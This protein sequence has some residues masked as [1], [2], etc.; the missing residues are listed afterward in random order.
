MLQL[1]RAGAPSKDEYVPTG[2]SR[3]DMVLLLSNV[4]DNILPNTGP[5]AYVPAG[6]GIG[7]VRFKD[8]Q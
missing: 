6:H 7:A 5:G 4:E 1:L 3:Q 8:G 2:H